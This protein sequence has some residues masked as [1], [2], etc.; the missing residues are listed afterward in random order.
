MSLRFQ[1][2][3]P[4]MRARITGMGGS[5]HATVAEDGTVDWDAPVSGRFEL[6]VADISLG[7]RFLTGGAKLFLDPKRYESISGEL[8]GIEPDGV[9]GFKTMVRISIKDLDVTVA[10]NGVFDVR[11]HDD[12]TVHG[13]TIS[14]PKDF[15]VIMPPFLNFLVHV[16]WKIELGL[17]SEA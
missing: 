3:V 8:L 13:R 11:A 15:G 17:T 2:S 5:F 10:A 9:T 7:N 4:G 14:D 6:K 1:P 16:K 12:I